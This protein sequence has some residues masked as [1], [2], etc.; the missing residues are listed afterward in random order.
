MVGGGDDYKWVAQGR[1]LWWWTSSASCVRWWLWEGCAA[2]SITKP[3]PNSISCSFGS[4]GCLHRRLL[5]RKHPLHSSNHFSDILPPK[6]EPF[7][8]HDKM[9]CYPFCHLLQTPKKSPTQTLARKLTSPSSESTSLQWVRSPW[10]KGL[11]WPSPYVPLLGFV[12]DTLPRPH[13]ACFQSLH[14]SLPWGCLPVWVWLELG[15]K[16]WA[17]HPMGQS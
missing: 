10:A 13:R 12:P 17:P 9:A 16:G 6:P 4:P 5:H 15:C 14:K 2:L 11:C 1:C 7:E 3:L 8:T